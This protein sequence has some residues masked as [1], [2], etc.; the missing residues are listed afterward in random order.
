MRELQSRSQNLITKTKKTK[1]LNT[2]NTKLSQG[3]MMDKIHFIIDS[4]VFIDL[5]EVGIGYNDFF[6]GVKNAFSSHSIST[7]YWIGDSIFQDIPKA[8]SDVK[9][10]LKD[11]AN[12]GHIKIKE[13]NRNAEE[14]KKLADGAFTGNGF[15][16]YVNP[17]ND[18]FDIDCICI[19][20]ELMEKGQTI[21]LTADSGLEEYTRKLDLNSLDLVGLSYSSRT[22]LKDH[23]DTMIFDTIEKSCKQ[24]QWGYS[25]SQRR[26]QVIA[27]RRENALQFITNLISRIRL[28]SKR[29]VK[30]RR[31]PTRAPSFKKVVEPFNCPEYEPIV[32]TTKPDCFLCFNQRIEHVCP[33]LE[34]FSSVDKVKMS[35]E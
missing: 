21:L 27:K 15:S 33:N 29:K 32:A 17:H 2:N 8:F 34:P 4:N 18:P 13:V 28:P 1:T 26:F 7:Y 5:F 23:E 31:L 3:V 35:S 11:L 30:R 22:L 12:D 24:K 6:K 25:Q 14:W 16:P 10:E 9:R 19:Q 20:N